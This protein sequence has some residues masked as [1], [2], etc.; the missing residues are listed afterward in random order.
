[1]SGASSAPS[2]PWPVTRP[3]PGDFVA[4]SRGAD[5]TVTPAE[6][7]HFAAGGA[8]GFKGAHGSLDTDARRCACVT[9]DAAMSDKRPREEGDDKRDAAAKAARCGAERVTG[10]HGG[11]TVAPGLVDH[12]ALLERMQ[13]VRLA[14]L[15]LEQWRFG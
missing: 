2:P 11:G 12:R 10:D 9:P 8:G 1:M 15:R 14:R 7:E 4:L 6:Y 13:D 5:T 3:H